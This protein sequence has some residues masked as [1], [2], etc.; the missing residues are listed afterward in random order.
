MKKLTSYDIDCPKCQC[1]A[2]NHDGKSGWAYDKAGN[3]MTINCGNTVTDI[4]MN[5]INQ[6]KEKEMRLSILAAEDVQ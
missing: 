6:L 4:L 3:K 5:E 1:P 2:Q